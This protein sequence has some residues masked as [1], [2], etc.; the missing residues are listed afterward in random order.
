MVQR[1]FAAKELPATFEIDVTTPKGD[2]PVY[3][4]M[5]FLRREVV[6]PGAKPL[7]L[8]DHA[9]QPL[10]PGP[11]DELVSLPNP[12]LIGSQ[13]PPRR[14]VRP[15]K[16]TMLQLQPGHFVSK[17]GQVLT[18]DFIKWP[19][20][21]AEE[22]KVDSIAYLIGGEAKGLPA[23]EDLAAARLVF[24][25]IRAHEHAPTKVGAVALRKPFEPD[26]K[27]D[28]ANLGDVVGT[29]I[30]P[31]MDTPAADW[32][33]PKQFKIDVTRLLR[34][35]INGDAAFHG[36]ALRVLPD[37]GI[38]DGYTVRVNLPKSPKIYLE[39]DTYLDA[40]AAE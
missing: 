8:P 18:S 20:V 22:G 23:Q 40:G 4:R 15:V 34:S 5:L 37:R 28:F 27:Y 6:S 39:I 2:F 29:V 38:D 10:A 1:T 19:K 26:A 7:P 35:V 14:E 17:T 13:P 3:P 21:A 24:P 25:A 31:K 12:F 9:Q 32:E 36:L 11:D 33:P 16:T 30:V